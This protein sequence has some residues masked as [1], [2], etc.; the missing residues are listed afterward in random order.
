V[1]Y[2][3]GIDPDSDRHGFAVYENEKLIVCATA[4][5][6]EI[7]IA[8]LPQLLDAGPVVFSIE[9]VMQNQF[10]YSRN[11]QSS[12]AAESKVAMHIGR[13]QQAQLELMRW[14]DHYRLPYVLH[15][16]QAG[17][18]KDKKALFEMLTGWTGRSN[19]DSRAAAFFGY[20]EVK[21]SLIR[22]TMAE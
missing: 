15:K 20:L 9:N 14:L 17:N 21:N 11:R 16:P 5:T 2:T 22:K 18:W 6:V 4:T 19:E 8:Q 7:M 12:K 10:V 1:R 3:V 13:C